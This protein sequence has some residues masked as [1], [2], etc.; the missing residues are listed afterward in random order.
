MSQ[1]S[2]AAQETGGD[3]HKTK[4]GL[5]FSAPDDP[6]KKRA[7]ILL[8]SLN[9]LPCGGCLYPPSAAGWGV[10]SA[11]LVKRGEPSPAGPASARGF[12]QKREYGAR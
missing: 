7:P 2:E 3:P 9:R 6:R 8:T 10:F 4:H 1:N 11:A 5:V 12:P